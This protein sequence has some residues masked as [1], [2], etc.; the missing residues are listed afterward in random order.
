MTTKKYLLCISAFLFFVL[1]SCSTPDAPIDNNSPTGAR[2]L[3]IINEG[4][5]GKGNASIDVWN[6]ADTVYSVGVKK[7]IGDVANDI[8]LIDGKHYIV[9]NGSNKVIAYDTSLTVSSSIQFA[10][11]SAPARIIKTADGEAMVTFLYSKE[12]DVIDTKADTIKYRLNV[13]GGGTKGIA[14]LGGFAYATNDS[15]GVTIINTATRAVTEVKSLATTPYQVIADSVRNAILLI[16]VG[17]FSPFMPGDLTWIKASDH[18][19]ITKITLPPADYFLS[20]Y[21]AVQ[22]KDKLYLLFGD[23]VAIL[24]LVTR[25][26][27]NNS[28]IAKGYYGGIY[29]AKRDEL[30]FGDAK[31]FTN[32]GAIDVY[33]ATT[34]VLK[35][36]FPSG[37]NPGHFYIY[38]K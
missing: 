5:F 34:G 21:P 28:F 20:L 15:N 13:S 36:S 31:D 33:D 7:A 6:Y 4:G 18:S 37:V 24:D 11:G 2:K 9:L 23:R 38:Q 30:I 14:V 8:Q 1:S 17:N 19:L 12:V 22:G 35:K 3:Y 27:T 10:A 29:D 25:T 32:N 16:G 26:I